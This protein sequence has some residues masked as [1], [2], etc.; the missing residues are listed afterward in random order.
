M[1]AFVKETRGNAD[2]ED[3]SVA[4][5]TARSCSLCCQSCP[6]RFWPSACDLSVLPRGIK[7]WT[8]CFALRSSSTSSKNRQRLRITR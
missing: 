6:I 2:D 7:E 8:F 1:H 5:S 3:E 4:T